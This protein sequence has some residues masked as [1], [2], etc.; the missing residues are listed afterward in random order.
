MQIYEEAAPSISYAMD[1]DNQELFDEVIH[2]VRDAVEAASGSI[3]GANYRE[4]IGVA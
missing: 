1:T 3:E 4:T 2:I